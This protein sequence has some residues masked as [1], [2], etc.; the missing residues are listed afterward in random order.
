MS[1]PEAPAGAAT[2]VRLRI[3]QRAPGRD[4]DDVANALTTAC[5]H[6]L[7]GRL[8]TTA[9]TVIDAKRVEIVVRPGLGDLRRRRYFGC[10][11][12][13]ILERVSARVE[14]FAVITVLD[15]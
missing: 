1:H 15:E 5:R 14:S 8:D 11:S 4:V 9:I 2:A 12:D 10:L 6:R 3:D 7:P 13:A